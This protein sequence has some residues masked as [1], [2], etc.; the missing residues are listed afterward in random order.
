MRKKLPI[1]KTFIFFNFCMFIFNE[2]CNIVIYFCL[3]VVFYLITNIIRCDRKGT[4][5]LADKIA[6]SPLVMY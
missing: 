2:Q 6:H 5:P 4:A 3:I 1:V